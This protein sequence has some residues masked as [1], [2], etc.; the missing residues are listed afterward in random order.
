[1]D[2]VSTFNQND[3]SSVSWQQT[4]LPRATTHN[5][6]RFRPATITNVIPA[7]HRIIKNKSQLSDSDSHNEK[8]VTKNENRLGAVDNESS[9]QS[10][11]DLKQS[12][13]SSLTSSTPLPNT[14]HSNQRLNEPDILVNVD[15]RNNNKSNAKFEGNIDMISNKTVNEQNNQSDRNDDDKY[16]VTKQEINQSSSFMINKHEPESKL[17]SMQTDLQDN[18]NNNKESREN[19]DDDIDYD[20]NGEKQQKQVEIK[21][22]NNISTSTNSSTE[23]T[24]MMSSNETNTKV[25]IINNNNK[26]N[27]WDLPLEEKVNTETPTTMTTISMTIQQSTQQSNVIE[28][29]KPTLQEIT[30]LPPDEM[31]TSFSSI[32]D[33][34]V[35]GFAIFANEASIINNNNSNNSNNIDKGHNQEWQLPIIIANNKNE[36]NLSSLKY[37]KEL[38]IHHPTRELIKSEESFDLYSFDGKN[39]SQAMV[40]KLPV[41]SV[42]ELSTEPELTTTIIQANSNNTIHSPQMQH[43]NDG[44]NS[45]N[46][47]PLGLHNEFLTKEPEE[48]LLIS[49]RIDGASSF[50][51]KRT[52]KKVSNSYGADGLSKLNNY[53]EGNSLFQPPIDKIDKL[54]DTTKISAF[55]NGTTKLYNHII[56]GPHLNGTHIYSNDTN[57]YCLVSLHFI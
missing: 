34:S 3:A 19:N 36:N 46:D 49:S 40:W 38:E 17:E 51:A 50:G 28:K 26:E 47:K 11:I 1:M 9:H 44:S 7:T 14:E 43:L 48:F 32:I 6:N 5:N 53:Y 42:I 35:D 8:I 31:T 16:N 23:S 13:P 39:R 52:S 41:S 24:N 25:I 22:K 37:K 12:L 33:S 30:T 20:D 54:F 21:N 18:N 57:L 45:N 15:Y 10:I 56:D 2:I 55:T 4:D 27:I 29:Q